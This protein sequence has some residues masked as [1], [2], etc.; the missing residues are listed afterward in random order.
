M[1]TFSYDI[2]NMFIF[3][4]VHTME[5]D[6]GKKL[7]TTIIKKSKGSQQPSQSTENTIVNIPSVA[8]TTAL[9]MP[10]QTTIIKKSRQGSHFTLGGSQEPS[11]STENTIVNIPSVNM[12]PHPTG[13]PAA[14]NAPLVKATEDQPVPIPYNG[15]YLI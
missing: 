11:Q 10:L 14:V 8:M 6:S 2:C 13:I 15:R 7:Q 9:P 12:P 3:I 1:P 4:S 5:R